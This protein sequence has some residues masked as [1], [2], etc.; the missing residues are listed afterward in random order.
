MSRK[1]S[2]FVALHARNI[3]ACLRIWNNIFSYLI[4]SQSFPFS[5]LCIKCS[6]QFCTSFSSH[7]ACIIFQYVLQ[8]LEILLALFLLHFS[9]L[10]MNLLNI[11]GIATL[12]K[13]LPSVSNK[14]AL[15]AWEFHVTRVY[16][17]E[18]FM[19][20]GRNCDWEK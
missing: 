7:I 11:S 5:T 13:A 8:C 6:S 10:S 17:P 15:I 12:R 18:I 1:H 19:N 4:R 20:A 9:Y 14:N 2:M 3:T 16:Q